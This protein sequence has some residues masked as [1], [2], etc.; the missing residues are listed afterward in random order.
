MNEGQHMRNLFL[1]AVTAV[2]LTACGAQNP[3]DGAQYPNDAATTAPTTQTTDATA[4]AGSAPATTSPV[5]TLPASTANLSNTQNFRA[6]KKQESIESDKAKLAALK[7]TYQ[8]VD[9]NSIKT[10]SASSRGV[11]LAAYALKQKNS[12]GEKAY[13][14]INVG[15]SNCSRYRTDP[16][17]AQR[18]FLRAGGPERDSRRLDPDGDG[19][20]CNW[21]PDFY[22]N[23][24]K[25]AG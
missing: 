18:A 13:R 20:A 8:Q 1:T 10:P 25:P 23:M 19:F 17:A 24:L 5:T 14:R 22:R 2:I 15:L 7:S 11:N 16:D 3:N 12:V 21:N 6:I 9:P 4:S